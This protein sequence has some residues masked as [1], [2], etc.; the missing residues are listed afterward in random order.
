MV[1]YKKSFLKYVIKS[2]GLTA[3]PEYW[4]G[5]TKVV[6]NLNPKQKLSFNFIS[7]SA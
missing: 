6:Y 2:A 4:N 3:V 7:F 5:Q 1:S